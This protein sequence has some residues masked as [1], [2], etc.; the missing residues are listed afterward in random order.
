MGIM[1]VGGFEDS[2]DGKRVSIDGHIRSGHVTAFD[3]KTR[4]NIS[5]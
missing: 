3:G 4:K 1:V 5:F 2:L